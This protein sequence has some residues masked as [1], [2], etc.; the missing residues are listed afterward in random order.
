MTI[1]EQSDIVCGVMSQCCLLRQIQRPGPAYLTNLLMKVN[2]KLGGI[3]SRIISDQVTSKFLNEQAC[4]VLGIDVTHPTQQEEAIGMPSV[5]AVVGNVDMLPQCFGANVK[6][7]RRCRESVVYVT[8][9][10]RDRILAFQAQTSRFPE[11]II[12]YRDGVSEGQF[13]E[14]LREELHGIKAA[15]GMIAADYNPPVTHIVVQKR[16]HARMFCDNPRDTIGR[17]KNIPPGTVFDTEV[18]SPGSFD[19]FLCSHFG[20]QVSFVM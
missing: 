14:V 4:L 1:K 11:R 20:I 17:A 15:C 10:I 3:N 19:F 7:Q 13:A 12:V 8:S 5:A 9:A 6:V 18:V 16:H 2:M